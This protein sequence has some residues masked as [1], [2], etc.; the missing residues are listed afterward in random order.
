MDCINYH[1]LSIE[2]GIPFLTYD[3]F[4]AFLIKCITNNIFYNYTI[5]RRYLYVKNSLI[6]FQ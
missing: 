2:I 3:N 5:I 6:L 1:A 4:H